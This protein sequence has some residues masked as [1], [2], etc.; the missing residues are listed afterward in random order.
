VTDEAWGFDDFVVARGPALLR[1]AYM[2]TGD[3]ALAEDLVQD[4]LIKAYR[5]WDTH[6]R[7][8]HPEAYVRRVVLNEHISKRRRRSSGERV[9][10]VPDHGEDDSVAE[11]A[12]RDLVWRSLRDLPSRQRGVLVLR[13]YEW[14]PDDE[15]ASLLGCAEG[16]VRSLAARAF[17]TMRRDPRLAPPSGPTAVREEHS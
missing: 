2:L 16:T 1:L 5:R 13:Y 8:Q 3:R 10:P 11:L 12:E 14:M 7:A 15:I 9:G 17:D 6:G 4:A